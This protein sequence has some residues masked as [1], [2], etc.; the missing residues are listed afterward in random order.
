MVDRC[1][2]SLCSERLHYLR[3]GKIYLF[4]LSDSD[5]R[6]G[7]GHSLEHHWLCG[8]CSALYRLEQTTKHG[9]HLVP[10]RSGGQGFATFLE[11]S[12]KVS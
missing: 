10:K 3:D 8:K 1:A 2:N 11:V 6:R 9:L 12:R 5:P 4:E 7:V